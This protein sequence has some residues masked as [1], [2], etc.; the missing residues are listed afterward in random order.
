MVREIDDRFIRDGQLDRYKDR[1]I[2]RQ[3]DR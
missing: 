1:R 3:I 2:D